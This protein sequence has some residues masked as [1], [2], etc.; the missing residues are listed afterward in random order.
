MPYNTVYAN[1]WGCCIFRMIETK[2][3]KV[4]LYCFYKLHYLIQLI[5]LWTLRALQIHNETKN[6][7]RKKSIHSGQLILKKIS[8][9]GATI[10]QA[11][12]LKCTKFDFRW[13]STAEP[14][15]G[16]YT[17]PQTPYLYLRGGGKGKGRKCKGMMG[18]EGKGGGKELMHPCRKFLATALVIWDCFGL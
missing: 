17:D 12:W 6:I 5:A 3:P 10:C 18:K 9:I 2:F 16:T 13:G 15:G 8:K 14:A 1:H 7:I 4:K 11:L